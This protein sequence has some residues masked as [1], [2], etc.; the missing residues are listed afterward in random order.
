MLQQTQVQTVIPYYERFMKRFPNV[1]ALAAA[2]DD[3]LL[4]HWQG[5]GYYRRAANLHKAAKQLAAT[6]CD[7]PDSADALRT[8]PGIGRYTAGAIASIAFNERA[9]VVD[10]NVTR[11]FARLFNISQD[12]STPDTVRQLWATA[13][14]LLPTR[15]CGDFN[16]ALMELGALI[17]TPTTPRCDDCPLERNCQARALN[18]QSLLPVKR[19]SRAVPEV[20]HVVILAQC[21]GAILVTKRPPDG[22]WGGLWE[23]PNTEC[24]SPRHSLNKLLATHALPPS[25]PVERIGTITHRLTHRLMHFNA[26]HC[27][28]ASKT[29]ARW[30][31]AAHLADLPMSTACRKLLALMKS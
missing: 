10:G 8:L 3:E 4:R 24:D 25:A 23:F 22:L 15:R 17:C 5:L 29:P 31:R 9:P 13:E 2:S 19:K 12:V 30:V 20:H 16:Q 28:V 26:F 6:G 18:T 11:V 7:M 14:C 27:Q 1:R 21:N